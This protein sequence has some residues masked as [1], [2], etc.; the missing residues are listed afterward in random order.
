MLAAYRVLPAFKDV[1][2]SLT[3]LKDSDYR[4]YAFSNGSEDAIES[5][6]SSANIR[7]YFL[8]IISVDGLRSFKPDP[9]VYNH[10]L[11]TAN[12][13]ASNAWLISCNPFDVIGA[14]SAGMKA[15]WLQRTE[16][17][18]FD[19]WGIEPTITISK[20]SELKDKIAEYQTPR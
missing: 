15:A 17:N 4:L 13:N 2:E 6:L 20:L 1:K 9:D 16:E 11:K 19:P 10:F 18:I 12:T 3:R 7:D 8:D 14:V 5:L